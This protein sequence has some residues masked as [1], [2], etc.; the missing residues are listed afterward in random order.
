MS[1]FWFRFVLFGLLIIAPFIRA[2]YLWYSGGGRIYLRRHEQSGLIIGLQYIPP[3]ASWLAIGPTRL[4][5][6]ASPIQDVLREEEF[7]ML[8]EIMYTEPISI[9]TTTTITTSKQLN[10]DE[11][12]PCQI[13]PTASD[14]SCIVECR[15]SIFESNHIITES[16]NI[17]HSIPVVRTFDAIVD[18]DV[19]DDNAQQQEQEETLNTSFNS[20]AEKGMIG[21]LDSSDND[22]NNSKSIKCTRTISTSAE[23]TTTCTTCSI[24]IDDFIIGETLTFLPR[25]V[26]QYIH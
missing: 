8:P 15:S 13:T 5:Q 6:P 26:V 12:G 19:L 16:I 25:Y 3:V 10:N 14:D 22:T 11:E 23:T 4:Q 20:A 9:S 17:Q 2:V 24:C 7:D 18:N 21:I 1:F